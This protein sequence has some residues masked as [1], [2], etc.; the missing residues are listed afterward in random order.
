MASRDSCSELVNLLQQQQQQQQKKTFKLVKTEKIKSYSR[1]IFPEDVNETLSTLG[2]IEG[3]SS[4]RSVDTRS[5]AV[6]FIVSSRKRRLPNL[7][8]SFAMSFQNKLLKVDFCR[9]ELKCIQDVPD[10]PEEEEDTETPVM[11]DSIETDAP[12]EKVA[13]ARNIPLAQD[14]FPVF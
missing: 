13:E 5:V 6:F 7:T 12:G 1:F 3:G 11:N 10:L 4:V 8:Q 2:S 14:P 9:A